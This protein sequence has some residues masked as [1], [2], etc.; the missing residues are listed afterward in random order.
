MRRS[1]IKGMLCLIILASMA[2]YAGAPAFAEYSP[3][4]ALFAAEFE[5]GDDR[6]NWAIQPA[7]GTYNYDFAF[8][9]LISDGVITVN[10][11][12]ISYGRFTVP[13]INPIHVSGNESVF[14]E[15]RLKHKYPAGNV[16]ADGTVPADNQFLMIQ[17]SHQNNRVCIGITNTGVIAYGGTPENFEYTTDYKI[18]NDTWYTIRATM[19]FASGVVSLYITDDGGNE[20]EGPEA[21]L[22][23]GLTLTDIYYIY[24]PRQLTRDQETSID[25]IRLWDNSYKVSDISINDGAED[26]PADT[27]VSVKFMSAPENSSLKNITLKDED[28][29]IVPM[30]ITQD[31]SSVDLYFPAGLKYDEKYTLTIPETVKNEEGVGVTPKEISFTTE[32][33]AF[34]IGT[35]NTTVNGSLGK[36][37]A[38]VLNNGTDDRDVCILTVVYNELNEAVKMTNQRFTVKAGTE[39]TI[40]AD[41]DLSGIS[42]PYVKAYVWDGVKIG[43]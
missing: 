18:Y 8:D 13:F 21:K 3:E 15:I 42:S 41:I 37:T 30:E 17:D 16:S 25:Y 26:V 38:E 10:P 7:S 27:G 33:P 12:V 4:I 24:T 22:S 20:F 6:T 9:D 35:L 11:Q 36:T 23:Y 14:F 28:A 5:D 31:G 32:P 34:R 2:I 19:N 1:V 29:N 43:E 39:E 40:S